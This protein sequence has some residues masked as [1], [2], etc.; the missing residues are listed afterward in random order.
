MASLTEVYGIRNRGLQEGP[1]ISKGRTQVTSV[2][3]SRICPGPR[4]GIP[5]I[6]V[7]CPESGNYTRVPGALWTGLCSGE[8]SPILKVHIRRDA[9]CDILLHVEV[10][11]HAP[12]PCVDVV[13]PLAEVDDAQEFFTSEVNG[14]KA[15][16]S[17]NS[18][19]TGQL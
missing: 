19:F 7:Y 6:R 16:E 5:E 4:N 17:L 11:R 13:G 15:K 1:K 3:R 2:S 8:L 10:L 9:V 12:E 14:A 18:Q